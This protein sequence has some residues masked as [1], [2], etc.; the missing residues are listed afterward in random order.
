MQV[1]RR[2]LFPPRNERRP[3]GPDGPLVTAI[4]SL[5]GGAV[6][7]GRLRPAGDVRLRAGVRARA[8]G[9]A[10]GRA[11]AP[12]AGQAARGARAGR[13][14]DHHGRPGAPL[15][16]GERPSGPLHSAPV[17][18]RAAHCTRTLRRCR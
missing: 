15:A 6:A 12:G 13:V 1:R 5:A 8:A 16:L 2:G 11:R 3:W 4:R 7:G 9:R 14:A 18:E 10:A 17:V